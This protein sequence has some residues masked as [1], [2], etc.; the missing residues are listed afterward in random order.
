V[1]PWCRTAAVAV[2]GCLVAGAAG[3][4]PQDAGWKEGIPPA[5][6]DSPGRT[7]LS[8]LVSRAVCDR[9]NLACH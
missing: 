2:L 6:E 3:E 8:R 4:T 7:C 1:N 5:P 9:R